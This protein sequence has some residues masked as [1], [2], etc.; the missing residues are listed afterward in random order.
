MA[1]TQSFGQHGPAVVPDFHRDGHWDTTNLVSALSGLNKELVWRL[2]YFS[3]APDKLALQY[4]APA[5]GIWGFFWWPYRQRILDTLHSLHG[6]DE[7][8][9]LNRR[10]DLARMIKSYDLKDPENHWKVGFLIHALGDSYAHTHLEDGRLKAY[11]PL[12]GHIFD[13]GSAGYKPDSVTAHPEVYLEYVAA[14]A[15]AL[16]RPESPA[17]SIQ[18][19]VERVREVLAGKVSG[20]VPPK[21]SEQMSAA[22]EEAL[23]IFREPDS[24]RWNAEGE[25]AKARQEIDFWK[26]NSF[27]D[28]VRKKLLNQ[29]TE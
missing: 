20:G 12:V 25:E 6:G 27:L 8:A 4:S 7:S 24:L 21:T 9:V 16:Q 10:R 28:D 3:Q 14:L 22:L 29:A 1:A 15:N 13:N 2:G 17:G 19:T 23:E 5:V 18:V 11:G 26:V